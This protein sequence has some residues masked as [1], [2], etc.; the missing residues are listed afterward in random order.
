DKSDKIRVLGQTSEQKEAK[1][2]RERQYSR[3]Y[4][5]KNGPPEER[6]ARKERKRQFHE[7]YYQNVKN[8]PPEE[9]EARIE[10]K[11]Q[12]HK[13]YYEDIR[14]GL[15]ITKQGVKRARQDEITTAH[16]SRKEK[17]RAND[18]LKWP[19]GRISKAGCR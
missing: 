19:G 14:N 8:E 7:K 4:Y 5:Q 12:Y 3:K 16:R 6:R 11:R 9:M 15:R 13:K 10:K 18:G 1:K 17:K 2:E